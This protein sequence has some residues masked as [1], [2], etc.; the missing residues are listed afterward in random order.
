MDCDTDQDYYVVRNMFRRRGAFNA[1][2]VVSLLAKEKI[3]E[4]TYWI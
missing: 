2:E 3:N 4:R 1:N